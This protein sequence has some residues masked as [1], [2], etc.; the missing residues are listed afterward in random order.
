MAVLQAHWDAIVGK[1]LLF[2]IPSAAFW[3]MSSYG[4]GGDT[5]GAIA[6]ALGLFAFLFGLPWNIVLAVAW[7]MIAKALDHPAWL[8]DTRNEWA[9]LAM[10]LIMSVVGASINGAIIGWST[11]RRRSRR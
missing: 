5:G 4:K 3:A 10:V 8:G 6:L 9:G 7:G 1:G 2:C 11:A